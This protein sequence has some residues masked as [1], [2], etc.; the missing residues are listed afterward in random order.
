[1]QQA[2]R[3]PSRLTAPF[4]QSAKRQLSSGPI[5]LRTGYKSKVSGLAGQG[6]TSLAEAISVTSGLNEQQEL[7]EPLLA[8]ALAA[9]TR[10]QSS[11]A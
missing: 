11:S 5:G 4:R 2:V 3:P 1:M 10:V 6:V 7:D 8:E 9:E